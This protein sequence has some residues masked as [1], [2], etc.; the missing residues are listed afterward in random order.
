[1]QLL[2]LVVIVFLFA[3]PF[4]RPPLFF[5]TLLFS[6]FMYV[7][8]TESWNLMGGYTGY[9]SLGHVTFFAI[10]AYTTALFLNRFGISPF[11]TAIL[12]GVFAATVAALVGYP[13]LRL[14]GAYFTI[15]TL[16]LAVVMQLIF[17][18]W[19]FVGSSTGLWFKLLP[20]T[21]ETNRLIFYEVMLVLATLITLLVRWV[22]KS[23]LGAG[24]IAIREDEDVAK[25]IGIN[26]PWLK[27]QAFILGAFF[28]GIVGGVYGY[29]MSYIHPD[30]TFNI[31][32]SL[33]IL[34]MAFFGGCKTWAGPLLG[35]VILSLANQ[36]IV[37]FIGAEISRILY[38]LLL[39]I[40]IIFMP[41]GVIEYIKVPQILR[42]ERTP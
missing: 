41:N 23:K 19:E 38:G 26:A 14:K 15:S 36:L 1:M 13:V 27:V 2:M 30:I 37:T 35:A 33:L 34:L 25:T 17:M 18:N 11:A 39:I 9:V 8:L 10:G 3:F 6:V 12:G 32:T 31:N 5:L 16:L 29:Y 28:A 22:E 20:V 24:L 4:I 21:M 42:K 7:G 40:V